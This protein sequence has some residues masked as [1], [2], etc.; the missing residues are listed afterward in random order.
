MSRNKNFLKIYKK[1]CSRKN[2][3]HAKCYD[4]QGGSADP[5][6]AWRLGNCE[7]PSCPLY[8]FRPYRELEGT[9]VPKVI[10]NK[11]IVIEGQNHPL[12]GNRIED[13]EAVGDNVVNAV[14]PS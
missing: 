10:S 8:P 5:A 3:I 12:M 13:I 2:A 7:I 4:C 9:P 6:L 14:E 11:G 1:K